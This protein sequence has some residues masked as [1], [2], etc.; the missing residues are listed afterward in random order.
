MHRSRRAAWWA[1]YAALVPAGLFACTL[2]S[3]GLSGASSP[4]GALTGTSSAGT[5]GAG[6]GGAGTGGTGG[7]GGMTGGNG[8]GGAGGR[9][10]PCGNGSLD[11][12][13]QCDDGDDSNPSDGCHECIVQCDGD[14]EFVHPVT[15]HC[16]R[17]QMDQTGWPEAERACINWRADAYLAAVTSAEE[18]D[19][20]VP[21]VPTHKW[22]GGTDQDNEGTYRWSSGE[23]WRYTDWD[24]QSGQPNGAVFPA[25]DCVA[26]WDNAGR[27]WHDVTCDHDYGSLCEWTPPGN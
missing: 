15:H 13:E 6:T 20:L 11:P 9:E 3:S 4:T 2:D 12:Q 22:I 5:G 1:A 24:T 18:S 25:E 8:P 26:L 16:Y 10:S 19:Y 14:T 21:R 23:D 27:Q 7:N 17:L